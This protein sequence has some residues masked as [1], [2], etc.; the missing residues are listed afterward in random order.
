[1]SSDANEPAGTGEAGRN[2]T[3]SLPPSLIG[4]ND[5]NVTGKDSEREEDKNSFDKDSL[6]GEKNGRGQSGTGDDGGDD[7]DGSDG[8][9]FSGWGFDV[10]AVTNN[11]GGLFKPGETVND[12]FA[13]MDKP[14]GMY[15]APEDV[16]NESMDMDFEDAGKT[17]SDTGESKEPTLE[18]TDTIKDEKG[19]GKTAA[20]LATAAT[21][22]FEHA[23]RAAQATFGK[24]AQELGRGWGTLNTFL[25]DMLASDTKR[26]EK[27]S[28]DGKDIHATFRELFPHLESDDEVV[29]HYR[30][31]LLQKYRCYLNNATPEKMFPLRG[32][33]FVTMSNIAM[34]VTDDGGAFGGIAFGVNVPFQEVVKIQKGA[35]A[36]LRVV[37]KAQTSFIFAE[38][39]SD[40][41]FNG[42]VS[43]LEQLGGAAG[44]NAPSTE[45]SSL[46]TKGGTDAVSSGGGG[47][48]QGGDG[49][50]ISTPNA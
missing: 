43:L 16:L 17:R 23:S 49:A 3:S 12:L 40:I 18:T 46:R 31:T 33:L 21:A 6:S 4:S 37:T 48:D 19:L 26:T 44:G 15:S 50:N 34:Y 22:E 47:D 35:K 36:M 24:A 20:Q 39:E 42:A 28:T 25:D 13:S 38:F 1:M 7:G 41:H 2:E 11:I 32:R 10:N 27:V 30:C 5:P 29:D 45:L 14:G 9:V 8:G